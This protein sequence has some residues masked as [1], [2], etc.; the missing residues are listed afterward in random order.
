[1]LVRSSTEAKGMVE[2]RMSTG[3]MS[4]LPDEMVSLCTWRRLSSVR[5]D[6]M[7][8]PAVRFTE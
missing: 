1:M 7:K 6:A 8:F 4:F 3:T 2:G 5:A